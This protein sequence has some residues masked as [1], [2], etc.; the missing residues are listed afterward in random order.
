MGLSFLI[1]TMVII[2]ITYFWVV[3]WICKFLYTNK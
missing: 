1:C 3:V 2:I